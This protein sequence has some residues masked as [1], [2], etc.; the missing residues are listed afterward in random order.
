MGAKEE[1]LELP[2][3]MWQ[4]DAT[5]SAHILLDNRLVSYVVRRSHRRRSIT[6]VIDERGLRVGAPWRA[7]SRAIERELR[8]HEAWVL[9]KLDE[10]Q[11]RRAQTLRWRE[12]ETLMFMGEP[13]RLALAPG[14]ETVARSAD[15]L[16]VGAPVEPRPAEIAG[17][18]VQWLREQAL[19]CFH[20]RIAHYRPPLAAPALEVRLSNARTRWGSCH[21]AGRILL[22]WRL[23]HMPLRLVDY[24]VVH[25]L[26]HLEEMNHSARFWRIVARVIPDYR[27]RRKDLRT[28]AHRYVLA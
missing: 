7:G 3:T 10:W 1:Q 22:N 24:V 21:A 19:A 17:R 25:E 12:G 2:F 8:A 28:E 9:R 27:A 18:V 6:L 15:R 23:I 26:A 16:I 20:D 11:Q 5:A 14:I 13:L 4:D